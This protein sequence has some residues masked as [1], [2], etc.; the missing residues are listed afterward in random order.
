MF[1]LMHIDRGSLGI[2]L[3]LCVFY[4]ILAL[5]YA[6]MVI[7]SFYKYLIFHSLLF[8]YIFEI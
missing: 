5:I 4:F 1:I 8:Q 2:I 3:I 7:P 6:C